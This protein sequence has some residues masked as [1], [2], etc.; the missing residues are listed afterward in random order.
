VL[1]DITV[2]CWKVR[3]LKFGQS[4]MELDPLE[5][6]AHCDDCRDVTVHDRLKQRPGN[7]QHNAAQAPE[8]PREERGKRLHA[9][10][11][12]PSI[13]RCVATETLKNLN[14]YLRILV[15]NRK[16]RD[17]LEQTIQGSRNQTSRHIIR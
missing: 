17:K 7:Q 8:R 1:I 14:Y 4:G 10:I 11:T 12:D 9:I 6:Q 3:K 13:E 16:A 15:P 5:V 2:D